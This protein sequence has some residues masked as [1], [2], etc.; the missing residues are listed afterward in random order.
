MSE[1]EF[2][3]RAVRESVIDVDDI[4]Q[5]IGKDEAG[6]QFLSVE[7]PEDKYLVQ[8]KELF[9][10][11]DE[12]RKEF[13][14]WKE[15]GEIYKRGDGT[16]VASALMAMNTQRDEWFKKWFCGGDTK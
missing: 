6:H 5:F 10:W 13:P 11:I 7:I 4:R 15:I 9:E 16:A 1:G 8:R 3:I 14:N 12:A 2:K